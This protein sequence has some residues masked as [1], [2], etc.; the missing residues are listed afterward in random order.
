MRITYGER[1]WFGR[2]AP[3]LFYL[4]LIS[5][6]LSLVHFICPYLISSFNQGMTLNSIHSPK[7]FLWWFSFLLVVEF[8]RS[9]GQY[10]RFTP[11]NQHETEHNRKVSFMLVE[12]SKSF[13]LLI[14]NPSPIKVTQRRLCLVERQLVGF[15][16]RLRLWHLKSQECYCL[17]HNKSTNLWCHRRKHSLHCSS[18]WHWFE[19]K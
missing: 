13:V 8:E 4:T 12:W 11:F 14:L 16:C 9:S 6:N 1:E 2:F 18:I 5:L 15:S 7:S 10:E 17:H 19:L 3:Q